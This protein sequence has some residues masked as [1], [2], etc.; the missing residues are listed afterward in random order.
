MEIN[1]KFEQCEY[2]NLMLEIQLWKYPFA[3]NMYMESSVPI[4]HVFSIQI[5]DVRTG[6]SKK[7]MVVLFVYGWKNFDVL[8]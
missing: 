1:L 4:W 3:M 5:W 6:L 2:W 7:K 8:V